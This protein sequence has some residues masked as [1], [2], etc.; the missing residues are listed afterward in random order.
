MFFTYQA[1]P[2]RGVSPNQRTPAPAA[3]PGPVA[4]HAQPCLHTATPRGPNT[5]CWPA[6]SRTAGRAQPRP[7][8]APGA[9]GIYLPLTKHLAPAPALPSRDGS[10]Q[11]SRSGVPAAWDGC[12]WCPEWG[13]R[14]PGAARSCSR[15]SVVLLRLHV[16]VQQQRAL[17]ISRCS[18]PLSQQASPCQPGRGTGKPSQA[19]QRLATAWPQPLLLAR[20]WWRAKSR[21]PLRSGSA[22]VITAGAVPSPGDPESPSSSPPRHFQAALWAAFFPLP[23]CRG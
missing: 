8:T 22:P 18:G 13:Q 23:L 14:G 17:P 6:P 5:G 15:L 2:T 7:G 10:W 21:T 12:S 1:K 20:R 3:P 9:A 16:G 19:V 11:R 4:R